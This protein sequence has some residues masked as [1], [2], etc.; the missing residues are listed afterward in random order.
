MAGAGMKDRQ[1]R[2]S[3]PKRLRKTLK[4]PAIFFALSLAGLIWALLVDGSSDGLAA[5][6]AGSPLMALLW[7]LLYRRQ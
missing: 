1:S 4:I 3:R 6:A 2:M 7:A 5:L